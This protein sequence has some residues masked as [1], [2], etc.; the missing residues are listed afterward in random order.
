MYHD[1]VEGSPDIYSVTPEHFRAHLDEIARAPAG[2]PEP[3]PSCAT[4]SG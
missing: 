2:P 4:A 3:W 1:V